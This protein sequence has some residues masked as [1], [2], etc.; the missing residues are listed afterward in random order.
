MEDYVKRITCM[1]LLLLLACPLLAGELAYRPG[2]LKTHLEK[3]D[4]VSLVT[5]DDGRYKYAVVPCRPG[6]LFTI[7]AVGGSIYLAWAFTDSEYRLLDKG[8]AQTRVQA[9]I[10]APAGA[11]YLITNDK[12]GR[13]SYTGRSLLKDNGLTE[14]CLLKP[15]VAGYWANTQYNTNDYSY[16]RS[17]YYRVS[18]GERLDQPEGVT[19]ELPRKS[20]S[21]GYVIEYADNPAYADKRV[22]ETDKKVRTH[23]VYNL[24]P[25]RYYWYTISSR[26]KQGLLG[27]RKGIIKTTGA[28]RFIKADS[29]DNIRDM[30]GL[31]TCDGRTVRYGLVYRGGEMN[32]SRSLTEEDA[33]ELTENVGIRAEIDFRSPYTELKLKDDDPT[34]DITTTPLGEGVLYTNKPILGIEPD[35]TGRDLHVEAFRQLL[36]NLK[37]GLPTYLHCVAGADRTGCFFML[38]EGILGV[39]ENDL[40]KDVE[41]TTF[42]AWGGRYRTGG[43]FIKALQC[44]KESPGATLKD[45]WINYAK[46]GGITDEEIDEF[47][48]IM[49]D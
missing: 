45:K 41:L 10:R 16:S 7:D 43:H 42:S 17:A 26:Q 11:A 33:R 30:G 36:S 46:A 29:A 34:N 47:T 12:G 25:G 44:A 23:T 37:N 22:I 3:G 1:L 32:L 21:L 19:L 6:D 13:L 49:L 28:R 8:G 4:K 2:A 39:G 24:I 14:V 27:L 35:G 48:A 20:G 18:D 9:E 40:M 31:E 38:I 5:I 15:Q